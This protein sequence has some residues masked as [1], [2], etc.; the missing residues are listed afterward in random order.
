M[1]YIDDIIVFAKTQ[2]Q[3]EA[4]L[5]LLKKRLENHNVKFNASRCLFSMTELD[6]LGFHITQNGIKVSQD[7][8]DSITNFRTPK[9]VDELSSFFGTDFI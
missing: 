1:I 5:V 8:I 2:S 7:K 3:H 9:T 4:R 6:F